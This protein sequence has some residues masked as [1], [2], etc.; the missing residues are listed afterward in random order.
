MA[1]STEHFCCKTPFATAI[2]KK[3]KLIKMSSCCVRTSVDVPTPQ[4][5]RMHTRNIDYN[6]SFNRTAGGSFTCFYYFKVLLSSIGDFLE[7][8]M[9]TVSSQNFI[10]TQTSTG[11][12]S[13]FGCKHKCRSNIGNYLEVQA[14]LTEDSS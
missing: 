11:T 9:L 1:S 13:G 7:M 5:S 4:I 3:N 6:C 8:I 10:H 2:Q 12:S 14:E